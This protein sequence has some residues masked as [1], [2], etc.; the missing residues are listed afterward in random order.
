LEVD[1]NPIPRRRTAAHLIHQHIGR[2]QVLRH[3]RVL[4]LPFCES[5]ERFLL[6]LASADLD[7][8][9][10]LRSYASLG[11]LHARRLARLLAVVRRPGGI[12]LPLLFLAR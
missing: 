4:F 8:R 6:I 9:V 11:R 7:E 12:P 3:A 10:L 1:P 2:L 5:D